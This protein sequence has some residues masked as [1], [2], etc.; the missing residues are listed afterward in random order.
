MIKKKVVFGIYNAD[1]SF[2]GELR[3]SIS[4][5][6]GK[7]SCSLCELTHGWNPFGKKNWK[8]VCKSS[9]LDIRLIHRDEATDSQL[10]AAGDLPSFITDSGDGW[11][12]ILK[13]DAI[14]GFTNQPAE[15]VLRLEDSLK[16]DW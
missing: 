1:G 10:E 4:K 6:I 8:T 5:V 7:S 9:D 3:Y 13:A 2:F 15:L 16:R 14:E 11:V 12:Q